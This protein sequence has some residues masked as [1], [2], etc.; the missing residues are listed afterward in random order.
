MMK[1]LALL[2][3]VIVCAR[4]GFTQNYTTITA[5]NITDIGPAGPQPL[6]S[7][8]LCFLATDNLDRPVSFQPGG[9]G[10]ALTNEICQTI[11]AGALVGTLKVPNPANTL[12]AGILYRIR[13]HEK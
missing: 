2:V 9:G 6:A 13:V 3:M 11:A 7:G 12:P 10:Q 5:T 8:M 1:R 4:F